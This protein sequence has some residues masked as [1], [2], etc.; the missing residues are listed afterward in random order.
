MGLLKVH[1]VKLMQDVG[2]S[3]ATDLNQHTFIWEVSK[4][5]WAGYCVDSRFKKKFFAEGGS[6]PSEQ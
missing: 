6:W 1:E 2:A 5:S 3:E 4:F